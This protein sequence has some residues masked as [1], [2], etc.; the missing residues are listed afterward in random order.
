MRAGFK[1]RVLWIVLYVENLVVVC[2][3]F[4]VYSQRIYLI[5]ILKRKYVNRVIENY[6]VKIL[7]ND[8]FLF[9]QIFKP[10]I[11]K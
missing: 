8:Y 1:Y 4:Y 5:S 2:V 6:I 3:L 11:A 7:A 10:L 9:T